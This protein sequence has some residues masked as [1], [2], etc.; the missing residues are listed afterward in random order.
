MHTLRCRAGLALVWL[1]IAAGAVSYAQSASAPANRGELI[2]RTVAIVAGSAITLSDVRTAIALGFV[3]A[4]EADLSAATERLV[5]RALMLREVERYAP[6]E[7]DA[8]KVEESV[9]QLRDRLGESALATILTSG[10]FS[11]V[12]LRTWIRDDVRIA[13][14]LDQRFA[15]DGPDRR[16]AL[17]EDWVADLR[18]RTPV[19]E[20]WKR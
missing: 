13:T 3:D 8:A 20:L 7:P 18:R 11:D 12:K 10:G 15:S 9:R 5:R 16:Q 1:V 4:E 19:V 2:E 6:Q 17:I 14:Y